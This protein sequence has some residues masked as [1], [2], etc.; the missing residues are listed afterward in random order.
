M[1]CLSRDVLLA[2]SSGLFSG[3]RSIDRRHQV[4]Y[5]KIY[6][7]LSTCSLR[8]QTS[9]LASRKRARLTCVAFTLTASA[10]GFTTVFAEI[11][12]KSCQCGTQVAA[13]VPRFKG[14]TPNPTIEE[15]ARK[16]SARS[17]L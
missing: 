1:N 9:G 11:A 2:G 5:D 8:S 3:G 15:D 6:K 4:L 13:A 7:P 14:M 16:N 12:L 10:I 17:S